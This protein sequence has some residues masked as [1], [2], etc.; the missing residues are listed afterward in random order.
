MPVDADVRA[1]DA[2]LQHPRAADL[3]TLA[4]SS[5]AAAL[6]VKRMERRTQQ[7]ASA[8]A[9]AN[10]SA[11]ETQTP[12]GNALEVIQRGPEDD[13]ERALARALAAH[14]FAH[15]PP[16]DSDEEDRLAADVLWLG[17]H[18]PFDATGLVD[19][20]LGQVA[21]GFWRALAD[22]IL[23]IDQGTLPASGKAEALVGVLALVSSS[24][25]LAADQASILAA[26]VRDPALSRLLAGRGADGPGPHEPLLGE[27]W[28]APRG[29][30]ITALLA[31]SG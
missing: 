13:A 12:F 7:V 3:A 31:A 25:R 1:Y 30:A 11:Q 14:A 27:L 23:R 24:S 16:K 21:P 28:P 10:L 2:L 5:L 4:W 18:T 6:Q 19:H 26:Q 15:R 8:A 29:P 17:T 9:D 20:A 22:R